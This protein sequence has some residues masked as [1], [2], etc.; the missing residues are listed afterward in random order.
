[1]KGKMERRGIGLSEA[2]HLSDDVHVILDQLITHLT[3]ERTQTQPVV[4]EDMG[5]DSPI[6]GKECLLAGK[7]WACCEAPL[8]HLVNRA[9]CGW[10][11]IT[12]SAS[13][14]LPWARRSK[15]AHALLF[16]HVQV[17]F[18]SNPL[19]MLGFKLKIVP[20]CCTQI[21]TLLLCMEKL[22]ALNQTEMR[23][24]RRWGWYEE[25]WS[26]GEGGRVRSD[27]GRGIM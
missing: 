6:V 12:I 22:L 16:T 14:I 24:T 3:C 5:G 15:V 20:F 21:D 10:V 26:R 8:P 17:Q 19:Y 13:T 27:R 11:E 23:N 1:M 4:H 2:T 18:N 9:V 7:A 25:T